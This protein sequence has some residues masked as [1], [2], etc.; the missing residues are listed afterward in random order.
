MSETQTLDIL[1][2]RWWIVLAMP[3][4]ALIVAAL[5]TF[6]QK[7][8]Y[9]AT[10]TIALAPATL[11]IPTTNQLPPY[12][13]T[14]DSPRRLP[15]AYT[16]TYY[17]AM[18]K[19]AALASAASGATIALG[20]NGNDRALIEIT[21]R[22]ADATQVANAANAY[23]NAGAQQI[24]KL[25]QP[26]D[27]DVAAAQKKLDAAEQALVKF[28]RDHNLGEYDPIKLSTLTGLSTDKRLELNRLLR[29]R[30]TAETVYRDFA[31]D[32]ARAAILAAGAYKP[33][34]IAAPT[35]TVPVA[36]QLAQ[37]VLI[38][39]AFGLVI[40][41]LGAFAVDSAQRKYGGNSA[42]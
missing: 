20:V 14:V 32:Y 41:I 33:R 24:E 5:V 40:G 37:N 19:D 2:R 30:D 15:P 39:A 1:R 26:N 11:S 9:E 28:T 38:G 7:P 22:G 31:G 25:L 21:A 12:Y 6:A 34:V 27:A 29:E 8:T 13:L 23:A 18:L 4:L 35:P 16:P 17:I 36:P 42:R 3:A 10:A